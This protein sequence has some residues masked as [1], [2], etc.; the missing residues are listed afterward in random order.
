[1]H[2]ETEIYPY[3]VTDLSRSDALIIAPHPDDESIGCGGTIVKHIKAGS[4]VKVIFLTD[5]DAGDFE[6]RFG[7]R[8][9][10]LRKASAMNAMM[11][12]GVTDYEFWSYKDRA[13]ASVEKE[14]IQRL[15]E[16]IKD[17]SPELIYA[18]SPFEVHPDHKAASMAVWRLANEIG[19][20]VNFYEVIVALYPN[21]LIDITSEIE[22]KR[23]AISCYHTE[24]Y[25]HDYLSHIE[26]LNR[27]RSL[28]LPK[29]TAF[30]EGFITFEK[31]RVVYS[32]SLRLSRILFESMELKSMDY[33][34][35]P[36]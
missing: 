23:K 8:Y 30:A 22:E 26:G 18:P 11:M 5:G 36:K 4:R 14:I 27:F 17:F 3:L 15:K 13:I 20:K 7:G 12:L 28:T 21:I 16:T 29:K 19:I 9:T 25:Y 6:G 1:M 31:D 32:L 33:H 2:K 35:C 34:I 10:E 24:L